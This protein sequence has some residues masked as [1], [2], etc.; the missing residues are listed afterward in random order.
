MLGSLFRKNK[1]KVVV[2]GID[3]VPCTLLREFAANGVM[4]N[5]RALMEEGTLCSLNAT[6]PEVS[7]TSWSSFMTGV[8]PGKH[9]IYGFMELRREDY[10]W[11][12]PNFNDL[13]SRTLWDI[14]GDHQKRSIVLNLPSTYPA[15]PLNGQL[16][17]GFVALDLK[18]ASYPESFYHYLNSAGY[19]LD[20]DAAKA[21]KAV[22][23][24]K[25]D[26]LRTFRKRI[27]VID[28]LCRNEEWDL[29]IAAIT[30]TDRLHHYLWSA[31]Q[32]AN[33]AHHRFFM[34][35]YREL[36]AFI[37]SFRRSI[38]PDI[39]FLMLSDHGFTGI[40]KEVYLNRFLTERGYLRFTRDDADSFKD[41]QGD[42]RAF[43][44]DPSRIYLHR[45][46]RYARGCVAEGDCAA[47]QT[48]LRDDLLALADNGARVIREVH[49]GEEIYSGGCAA[50]APDLVILPEEGYDLKGAL[51]KP[52][53]FGNGPLTGGHTRHNAMFYIN[54]SV[55]CIEPHI[56][57]VGATVLSL[58]GIEEAG[59]DGRVLAR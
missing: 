9:G 19:R 26:I 38:G 28:H 29:F 36:D 45:K 14:A 21:V 30:E 49:L 56:M 58:L 53:L 24:F 44:L 55:E 5:V 47:L 43:A 40:K 1:K 18:K 57:D 17:A 22:E 8:N 23:E 59:L 4:P 27:E 2:L 3:G 15:R 32:D 13:K 52:A 34:D 51:R 54:R 6:M 35:F 20:V 31:Y 48:Q 50:D 46:D 7:S 10:A 12:F 25:E 41:I 16:V 39:P 37:G 42:S 11:K 33:S